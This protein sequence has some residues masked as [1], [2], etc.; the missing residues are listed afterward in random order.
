VN[1]DT[2]VTQDERIIAQALI[3]GRDC[4]VPVRDAAR[5][6]GIHRTTFWRRCRRGTY[7]LRTIRTGHRSVFVRESELSNLIEEAE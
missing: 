2:S 3:D 4:L 1:A 5:R 7:P 6:L